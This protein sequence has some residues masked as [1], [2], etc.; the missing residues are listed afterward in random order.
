MDKLYNNYTNW[1]YVMSMAGQEYPLKS[2]LDIVRILTA[3][4][5]SNVVKA[6]IKRFVYDF[7]TNKKYL[8]VYRLPFKAK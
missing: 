3:A 8:F 2:N 5:G 7:C 1:K 6:S 4:N